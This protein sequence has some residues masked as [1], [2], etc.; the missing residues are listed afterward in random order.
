MGTSCGSG[1]TYRR[2]PPRFGDSDY[3]DGSL[4]SFGGGFGGAFF[5]GGEL[6][7]DLSA[8]LAVC[9]GCS[10]PKLPIRGAEH[11]GR[12]RPI[13]DSGRGSATPSHISRAA[14]ANRPVGPDMLITWYHNRKHC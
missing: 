2:I 12:P 1:R 5:G 13:A 4:A 11:I 7:G 10:D 8:P 9:R 14:S 3:F 6:G